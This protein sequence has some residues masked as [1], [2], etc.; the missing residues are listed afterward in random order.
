[1]KQITKVFSVGLAALMLAGSLN[2]GVEAFAATPKYEITYQSGQYRRTYTGKT[3]SYPKMSVVITQNGKTSTVKN[4]KLISVSGNKNGKAINGYT[5]KYT[6]KLPNGK[7]ITASK[8]WWIIP[9]KYDKSLIGL[10]DQYPCCVNQGKISVRITNFKNYGCTS[11]HIS[12]Y[13]KSGKFLGEGIGTFDDY[14]VEVPCYYGEPVTFKIVTCK[15]VTKKTGGKVSKVHIKSDPIVIKA[16]VNL[17]AP[18]F[19]VRSANKSVSALV[20]LEHCNER[21]SMP[22]MIQI[23]TSKN[24]KSV[25]TTISV[26]QHKKLHKLTK[27][28]K[29][30]LCEYPKGK[31]VT[32]RGR[33]VVYSK[34]QKKYIYGKWTKI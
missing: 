17:R 16:T 24:N 19:E 3:M 27:S 2:C 32:V 25:M 9:K 12:T 22:S 29:V 15:E 13:N 1:M 30:P 34:Y 33:Y 10:G 14:W 18:E 21:V 8:N 7:K 5:T 28:S 26:E 23:Q 11:C 6:Y 4:A 31:N 20:I